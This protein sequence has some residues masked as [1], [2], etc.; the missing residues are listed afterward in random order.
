[1]VAPYDALMDVLIQGIRASWPGVGTP[2]ALA[3]TG[4][5]RGI[6]RGQADTNDQYATK[7]TQ[8]LDR[9]RLAGTAETLAIALH[10]YLGDSPRVRVVN[11]AGRWLT[12]DTDG[13]ITRDTAAWDWD[14][15][16]NPERS[17]YWSE[18]W[19]IIYPT[20]WAIAGNWG[21]GTDWGDSKDGFGHDVT[22][23]EVDAVTGLLAQW[24]SAHTKVR[25]V[26]W[27]SDGTLFDPATPA[28]LPD[29]TW[30]QWGN[31][32]SGTRISSRNTTTCRYWEPGSS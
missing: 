28:S 25:T 10:E 26:I 8:W 13:T 21:D 17:G 20:Q 3:L 7:L 9:W 23:Q 11:R 32:D 12:V 27:T 2:T 24:K 14:S 18:I 22:Q 29:G 4:R 31:T 15:V 6:I 19:V 30:G 16:S 1:M 5:S